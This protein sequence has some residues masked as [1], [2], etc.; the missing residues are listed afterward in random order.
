MLNFR[1][2]NILFIGLFLGLL[3]FSK[4]SFFSIT[5][6]FITWSTITM[7]GSFNIR[8]N[9]F[10]RAKNHFSE[11]NNSIYLTFD[12]GPNEEFTPKVL[13]LL[14]VHHAKATF[15]C[16]GENIQKHPK[17]FQQI[18]DE[19]HSIGNHSF[20][21]KPSFGFLSTKAVTEDIKKTQT[22][23]KEEFN[24]ETKLFRPP[25]GI[26]NPNIAKAVET[27]NLETIGWSV[28]SFDTFFKNPEMIVK[29]IKP[30]IKNGSVVL[31][32]D[33][34]QSSV[35]LLEL[36]LME[37]KNYSITSVNLPVTTSKLDDTP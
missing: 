31:L 18:I 2:I 26:T 37:L 22:L 7:L 27:L 8:W 17:V 5:L 9:Y 20:S 13:E 36:L 30:Q 4:L 25:F 6:L 32:H 24:L 11:S 29:M 19:G 12:D 3:L 35:A 14:K 33:K 10:L 15:F 23:M 1:N 28:R 21:H 34:S 16:I